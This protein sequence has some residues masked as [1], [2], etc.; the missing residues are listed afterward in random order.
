M[1][2]LYWVGMKS[3]SQEGNALAVYSLALLLSDDFRSANK[4]GFNRAIAD[5]KSRGT[6]SQSVVYGL[7]EAI[8]QNAKTCYKPESD[9][10]T[11]SIVTDILSREI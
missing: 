6:S 3:D 10:N 8:T 1:A 11:I 9:I 4:A 5:A 2:L 7:M